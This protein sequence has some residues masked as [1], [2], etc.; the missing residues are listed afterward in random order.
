[1][2]IK[3]IGV[4]KLFRGVRS[5]PG[6]LLSVVLRLIRAMLWPLR[7]PLA[8]GRLILRVSR[9]GI[10]WV[11][12]GVQT[13]GRTIRRF[14][15]RTA[16]AILSACRAIVAAILWPF[17][18]PGM[19]VR[20]IRR[21]LRATWAWICAQGR[22]IKASPMAFYRGVIRRRD[23][24]LAKVEYLQGESAKWKALF[25]TLK[26][27]YSFLRMMG[28][29]PQMATGLLVAGST[30]GGSVVV[31][32]TVFAE[33]SFARGDPGEYSAPA[34]IPITYSDSDNTLRI[35]LSSVPVGEITIE[36]VTVGTAYPNSA[37]PQGQS[38]VVLVGGLATSTG[39]SGTYLEVGHLIID[40][41][42]CTTFELS[43]SEAHTLNFVGIASDGQSVS[44]SPGVPRRRG[45]GGGNRADAMVTSGG[46]YDQ[47]VIAAPVS[48]VNG[49]VEKLTLSNLYTKGGSCKLTRIK[50]G[51]IDV[52]LNEVGSGNGFALKDLV[53]STTTTYSVFNN[54]DN[55]EVS[56][57]PPP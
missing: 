15:V 4:S 22:M 37:L 51:T 41:S 24:V 16:Q 52:I 9:W 11:V 47:I 57:A 25:R 50:A 48:G 14:V 55:V 23:W 10:G 29:S 31:S 13:I 12:R 56:I 54:Q 3:L 53:I 33:R 28:L 44:P 1:M 27:P 21:G 35:N 38:S 36:D 5:I 42:R 30:V 46:Y 18:I 7:I 19:I 8:T 20:L 26:A 49:K 40:R 34:D 17:R 6:V 45:I 39:F 2:R 43:H 32:E